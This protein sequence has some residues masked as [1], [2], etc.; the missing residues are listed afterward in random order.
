MK[1][2]A[3][4]VEVC[5]A[6]SCSRRFELSETMSPNRRKYAPAGRRKVLLEGRHA[7]PSYHQQSQ[8]DKMEAASNTGAKPYQL[9]PHSGLP[10]KAVR[11]ERRINCRLTSIK[12]LQAQ[13]AATSA[14]AAVNAARRGSH[15]R[16]SHGDYARE[17]GSP[18]EPKSAVALFTAE[19]TTLQS[20]CRA[21][22]EP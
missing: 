5:G 18:G 9:P 10:A 4:D 19:V 17:H 3:C 16:R 11:K 1:I 7:A 22:R 21:D 14:R 12:Y 20:A 15:Y 8:A 2:A 13:L 6:E